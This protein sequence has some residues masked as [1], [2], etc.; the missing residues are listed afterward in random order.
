MC[1]EK[2]MCGIKMYDE[3][4]CRVK[5]VRRNKDKTIREK[6]LMAEKYFLDIKSQVDLTRFLK[7]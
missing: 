2:K 1:G 3:K 6:K 7:V 5:I 4:M